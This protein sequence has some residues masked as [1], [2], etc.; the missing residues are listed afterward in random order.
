VGTRAITEQAAAAPRYFAGANTVV[1][2]VDAGITRSAML[3]EWLSDAAALTTDTLGHRR[4]RV[5]HRRP[6]LHHFDEN[7][8]PFTLDQNRENRSTNPSDDS[9]ANFRRSTLAC[10]CLFAA[11]AKPRCGFL[12]GSEVPDGERQRD[13]PQNEKGDNIIHRG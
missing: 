5:S 2:L 12:G 11:P 8:H 6:L 9:E 10:S 13:H 4:G 1:D 3:L 7:P